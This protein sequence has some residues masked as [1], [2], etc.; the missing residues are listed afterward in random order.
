[1]T[2]PGRGESATPRYYRTR[3]QYREL[4]SLNPQNGAIV[5]GRSIAPILAQL[6]S[7][8]VGLVGAGIGLV[9]FGLAGGWWGA[10]HVLRPIG[11]ISSAA[12]QIAQGDRSKR[13]NLRETESEL[14][15]L[16]TV[17]NHTFDRL[18][19]AFSRQV[20]FTADASH[21]LRTPVSVILTQTQ[22]ALA[23]ERTAAE[24][25]ESL[26]ICRRAAERLRALVNS[27]LDLSRVDADGLGLALAECDLE[28][29]AGA[30]LEL[31]APLAAQKEAVLRSS[32]EPV[33]L[34]ADAAKLERVMVNL[35]QNAL[36]HNK[37]GV[38]VRLTL[39]PREG[40]V[41]LSVADNGAGIPAEALPRLFD[42][43]FR[44]DESRT[45]ATGGSGLGLAI[46]KAI[47][48]AHG[49]SIRAESQAGQGAAF[50]VVLP[51]AP[52]GKFTGT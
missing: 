14:G 1:M 11:Q 33:R 44:V 23:R 42:R 51:L 29:V 34:K 24:Y 49:G 17:L 9:V 40:Y 15:Q 18:D 35:L 21:E 6:R 10:G 4:V 28:R 37:N 39:Q 26:Q 43:F 27:L 41:L 30:A 22:L 47:V 19:E 31:V 7:L 8:A 50:H 12:G 32:V 5:V 45:G 38:E 2:L 20:Q 16:A 48:E 3:G 52:A 36:Q 46:C 13:I 25:R